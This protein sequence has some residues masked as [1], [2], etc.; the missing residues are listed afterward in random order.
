VIAGRAAEQAR[1]DAVLA[2]ARRGHSCALLLYG[3]AGVGKS[4][5]LHYAISE[6]SDMTVVTA[7][8]IESEAEL[9]FATL[10]Q[11]LRPLIGHIGSLPDVQATA[12]RAALA[13][14]SGDG[15]GRLAVA[16]ATLGVLATAG[17][18]RPLLVAVDDLQW[19]DAAS[20]D[21]L[22]FAVRRLYA[23]PVA[24]VLAMRDEEGGFR[25][26]KGIPSIV[27]GGLA[28]PQV[29]SLLEST[30]AGPVD[31]DV[32]ERLRQATDGNPLALTELAATLSPGQLGGAEPL[33]EPL[34]MGADVTAVFGAR[35]AALKGGTET[36]LL[37]AAAAG[38]AGPETVT[39]A[40]R[41]LGGDPADL[42]HAEDAHLLR[43]VHGAVEFRHPLV[44]STVYHQASPAQRRAAH[45]ALGQVLLGGDPERAAWQL[46]AATTGPDESVATL[47]EAAAVDAEVIGAPRTASTT[48]ER[49]AEMSPTRADRQRRLVRGAHDALQSGRLD[50]ANQL[51]DRLGGPAA[52]LSVDAESAALR[53]R[54]ARLRGQML[55]AHDLLADAGRRLSQQDRPAAA[56]LLAEAVEAGM[57][58]A[59]PGAV[60]RTG[61][62]LA[63]LGGESGE[64]AFLADL[65]LGLALE[66]AGD[67]TEGPRLIRRAIDRLVADPELAAVPRHQLSAADAYAAVGGLDLARPH[68]DRAIRLSRDL[69]TLGTLPEA[70]TFAAFLD[71]QAGSWPRATAVAVE[72]MDLG[73]EAGQEFV[74]CSALEILA[75][76]EA[77]Q[78]R[79]E[80]FELHAEEGVRRTE[81]L[82]LAPLQLSFHRQAG[83]LDLGNGR[84]DAARERLETSVRYAQR[85]GLGH[86][87][88]SPLPDL[89]EVYVRS[90]A[91]EEATALL[92]AIDAR[93]TAA[94]G[95]MPGSRGARC[96]GMVADESSFDSYFIEAVSLGQ[97]GGVLYQLGRTHLCYGERLRRSGRRRDARA[98]L[99]AALE[100]FEHLEA[101]PW[102]KRARGELQATGATVQSHGR[103][104]E[105]LTPQEQQIALLVAE[106]RSNPD[107]GRA[108]YLS[109]RTVEFHLSRVYRKL[110]ISSRGELI[111]RYATDPSRG[112]TGS[113]SS[114]R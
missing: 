37:V 35:A 91:T 104:E 86:A 80:A 81:Q 82:G 23:D 58:V 1:L 53:G 65:Y 22:L 15:S 95:P 103:S 30:T 52:E 100:I 79:A 84:L 89:L 26:P 7:Q 57:E 24:V 28:A 32:V 88:G 96:H 73:R 25:P 59:D 111:R 31:S 113:V 9:S 107:V 62:Q 49:A 39:A 94:E 63:A 14:Q 45:R 98:Q 97:R 74:L 87:Y 43:L 36:A 34:A 105:R 106:G 77:A 109:T 90:G 27:V 71:Y 42:V 11:L 2:Q 60:V 6:A 51:L 76:I 68:V 70:L 101:D 13:L 38:D 16:A 5:L 92:P 44:R 46:A 54:I 29:R 19:V 20:A 110:K 12:L 85:V 56:L 114:A 21:T 99:H 64:S 93:F 67:L 108:L 48:W 69:G 40:I 78:G 112:Q 3:E 10:H 17:V 50:R 55:A 47:L 8:G 4:T 75:S 66:W 41:S 33:H 83:V 18:A 72:A 61:R 102:T